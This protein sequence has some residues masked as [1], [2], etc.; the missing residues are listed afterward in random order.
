MVEFKD[1]K[2]RVVA[3]ASGFWQRAKEKSEEKFLPYVF[4]EICGAD[5][6][7]EI[8]KGD[9]GAL[10]AIKIAAAVLALLAVA[11]YLIP[12]NRPVLSDL[13]KRPDPGEGNS[14]AEL[15]LQI[16]Y[17]GNMLRENVSLKLAE[18]EL[19][20]EEA[21]ELF[22]ECERCLAEI[23]E[24]DGEGKELSGD[25]ELPKHS[26]DGLVDIYWESSKPE[27]IDDRGRLNAIGVKER[28]QVVLKALMSAGVHSREALFF[29]TLST[30]SVEDYVPSLR[31]ESE[32]MLRQ[33]EGNPAPQSLILPERSPGGANL[34]WS[35]PRKTFPTELPAMFFLVSLGIFF[36]RHDSLEKRLRRQ[37]E[38]FSSEIPEMSLQLTL[39]L[40][41]GL[42]VSAAFDEMIEINRDSEKPLYRALGRLRDSSLESNSSFV[43]EL[44]VYASKTGIR[45]FIRFANL[46]MDGSER[47][48]ELADK[49]ER[50]R[51]QQWGGRLNAAK[52]R[53]KE[54][55]TKL[56]LPLMILLI[57]LVV[58]CVAP[59][60]MEM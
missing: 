14:S 1:Y 5:I 6:D 39:L 18:R 12:F 56:C 34:K 20:A 8:K 44:Y 33:I 48:S 2:D 40:N 25:L 58:I 10:K 37:K 47:G 9:A 60:M 43:S 55:E 30:D 16:D 17:E 21:D 51:Q 35:I 28:T 24:G 4:L 15:Q 54:A 59:A 23:I 36:S 31:R 19:S 50:E 11:A 7:G 49:L 32:R 57:I 46:V 27:I 29:V 38:D 26:E 3:A 41:A 13:L 52:A 22:N 42:V 53:A 45:E